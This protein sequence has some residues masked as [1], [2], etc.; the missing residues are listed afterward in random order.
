VTLLLN[1]THPVA[2]GCLSAR[3]SLGLAVTPMLLAR[4]DEVIE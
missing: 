1:N 2:R 3:R 4:I